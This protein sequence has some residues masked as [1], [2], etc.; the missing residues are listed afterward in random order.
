MVETSVSI[1]L[2]YNTGRYVFG[3]VCN[4]DIRYIIL[5]QVD[6]GQWYYLDGDRKTLGPWDDSQLEELSRCGTFSPNTLF[7]NSSFG[8]EWKPLSSV[9]ELVSLLSI[10]ESLL[11]SCQPDNQEKSFVDD[12]GTRY[13]WNQESGKYVPVDLE[14][15]IEDMVFP[16]AKAVCQGQESMSDMGKMKMQALTKAEERSKDA[17][18]KRDMGW[19]DAKKNTSVY[20]E[21]LPLDTSV[22]EV[23]EVF[24]KCG[25]IKVDAD[26]RGP[27]IKLYKNKETGQ[28]QGDGLVTYLKAPSVQLAIDILDGTSL[29]L[30]GKEVMKVAGAKFEQKGDTYITQNNKVSK[31]R[32]KQIVEMLEKKALGWSGF[33]DRL[34]PEM[35]TV[36]LKNM[37]SPEELHCENLVSEL[38][39]DVASE[40]GKFG[41]IAKVRVFETNPEGVVVVKFQD[42]KNCQECIKALQGRWFGGRQI[43][44]EVWD[45]VTNFKVRKT[46]QISEEEAQ[47]RLDA[48]AAELEG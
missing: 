15:A 9:P 27:R 2:V 23:A 45:G 25:V 31:K 16:D 22:E 33:D 42:P 5:L 21:G 39:E 7:W 34:R 10:E 38:E 41:P 13:E 24:S 17:K 29:R 18:D 30:G 44:A 6:M 19:F 20:I 26:T 48:Y 40:C 8:P 32:K 4:Y 12:D 3:N 43:K 28:P 35:V 37:F 1:S 36:V 47:E 11:D 46:D 14:Y